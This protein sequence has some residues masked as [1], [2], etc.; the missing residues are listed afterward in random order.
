MGRE[1][2]DDV[3]PPLFR[4]GGQSSLNVLGKCLDQAGV[5]WPAINDTPLDS[6]GL[7]DFFTRTLGLESLAPLPELVD[8]A[9][10]GAARV[11]GVLGEGDGPSSF[12]SSKAVVEHFLIRVLG[13]GV[14]VAEHDVRFVRGGLGRDLIKDLAH[15]RALVLGPFANGRATADGCVLLLDFGSSSLGYEGT[16]IILVATEGDQIGISLEGVLEREAIEGGGVLIKLTNSLLKKSPTSSVVEGPPMFIN[17][18]AV[19]PFL[20]VL[21]WVT[22]GTTVAMVLDC[23]HG[24][25]ASLVARLAT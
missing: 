10:G 20:L 6:A 7:V 17:T 14:C 24:D 19:G 9:A 18:I 21:S 3:L 12:A 2:Q 5:S 8:G 11:L 23:L 16:D 1:Q 25:A 15:F 22:G 4:V 13:Q